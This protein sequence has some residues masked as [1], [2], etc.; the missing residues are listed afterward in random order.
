MSE[1]T[2]SRISRLKSRAAVPSEILV[3]YS[4]IQIV[5]GQVS[6]FDT[7]QNHM[8]QILQI[9]HFLESPAGNILTFTVGLVWL[10]YVVIKEP[11]P[12]ES[13]PKQRSLPPLTVAESS[14]P[15][16]EL[17]Y[18][19]IAGFELLMF[20]ESAKVALVN[21]TIIKPTPVKILCTD[22]GHDVA[23]QLARALLLLDFEVMMN[24]DNASQLFT[25]RPDQPSGIT[26]RGQL[27]NSVMMMV[28]TGLSRAHLNSTKIEFP[29]GDEY[30]YT[31]VEI[32]DP[33]AD[34][35]WDRSGP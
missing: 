32:G 23:D 20:M 4:I 5:I 18:R 24:H 34:S 12:Q 26:L 10:G 2:E 31:Q 19:P 29:K 16:S 35:Y 25:A 13:S 30:N 8:N 7:V 28:D 14:A 9:W 17:Q 3:G 22:K 21:N 15:K 27:G 11:K 6:D 1:R 33:A